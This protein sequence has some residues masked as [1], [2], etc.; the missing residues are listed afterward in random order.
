MSSRCDVCAGAG[1][2]EAAP[3]YRKVTGEGE[4]T[5]VGDFATVPCFNCATT[6]LPLLGVW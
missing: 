6:E 4:K 3:T 2:V 1:W 5:L